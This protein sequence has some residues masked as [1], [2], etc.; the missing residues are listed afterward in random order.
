MAVAV[1]TG[2][3]QPLR[4]ADDIVRVWKERITQ[5]REARKLL[6]RIWLSNLAFAAGQ[7]WLVW[8]DATRQMRKISDV[9]ASYKSRPLYT[10]D[11]INEFVQAQLG[12]LTTGDDRPQLLVAQD[13]DTAEEV[14]K[15]LNA[16]VAYAW[17]H[18]WNADTALARARSYC[19]KFGV[20]AIRTRR[21]PN[22]GPVVGRTTTDQTG[23]KVTDQ[24]MLAHLEQHG[25]LPDGSLPHFKDV[26]A[27]AT[28]WEP[29]TALQLLTPPGVT[30]EDDFP[31]EIIVRPVPIDKVLEEYPD[32]AAGLL[33]DT[34]IATATG[35]TTG[36]NT[37]Q[38]GSGAQQG[39]L[40]EHVWLYTCYERPCRA[41]PEGRTVVIASNQYRLL[42]I[43]ETLPCRT[44]TQTPHSGVVYFHWWRLDDRFN[45]RSFI[46]PLKDPQRTINELKTAEL[47]IIFRGLPKVF[48]QEGTLVQNPTGAPLENVEMAEG[49]PKPDFFQGIGPGPWMD[50]MVAASIDDL[51]H[52]ATLSPLRLGENP[53]GVVT[54]AQLARLNENEAVKRSQ[55]HTE[56]EGNIGT[57]V[58]L[59][60]DD[61]RKFWPEQ[62]T[63]MVAGDED[64]IASQ[65]FRKSRIPDWFQ[66]KVAKGARQ[67]RT[68]GAEL[69]KIDAIWAAA[70]AS[71]VV[72]TDPHRWTE[73][74]TES[75]AAAKAVDLPEVEADSQEEMAHFEN[76][77]MLDAGEEVTPADYDLP[78]VHIPAHRKAQDQAR[79]AGDTAAFLRIQRHVDATIALAQANAA[80][81]AGASQVPSPLAAAATAAQPPLPGQPTQ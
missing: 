72:A 27:G 56:H 6:E 61:I 28:V 14:A 81:V 80:K 35:L 36:Q 62:K 43:Q 47:E 32:T 45:S 38:P 58:E 55:I 48:T 31:W 40:R 74:Y 67:P 41:Y 44:P 4:S 29:F 69:A 2:E 25:T 7:H 76:F 79:A 9:D 64:A 39:R 34:D 46:E 22:K 12:E 26:R 20:S 63:I 13:G 71:G 77:L 75:L 42:D 3:G 30:H 70:L 23:R 51:S 65:V 10:A 60:V 54:Y 18:E 11:R 50:A 19:L 17:E 52:A 73:W 37:R 1:R 49:A 21:D 53:A 78:P 8:D 5:A 66:A 24:A 16:C 15:E 33:E 57:L 59:S 68:Q